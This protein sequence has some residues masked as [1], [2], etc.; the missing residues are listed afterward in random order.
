MTMWRRQSLSPNDSEP[1]YVPADT[2]RLDLLEELMVAQ[3]PKN[4]YILE[5]L[6]GL[7]HSQR[8][9]HELL[10]KVRCVLSPARKANFTLLPLRLC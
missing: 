3:R 9:M 8:Q 4:E 1:V 10:A 2:Q 5:Q 7:Q 6:Q